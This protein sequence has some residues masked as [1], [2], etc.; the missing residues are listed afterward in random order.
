VVN[1]GEQEFDGLFFLVDG[2]VDSGVA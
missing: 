2:G 1:L